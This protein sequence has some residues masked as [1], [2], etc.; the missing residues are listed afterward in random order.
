MVLIKCVDQM[1]YCIIGQ[2]LKFNNY[3]R[4]VSFILLNYLHIEFFSVKDV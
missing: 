2:L 1:I 3:K 4:A